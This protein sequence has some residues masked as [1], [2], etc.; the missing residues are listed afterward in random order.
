MRSW[1]CSTGSSAARRRRPRRPRGQSAPPPPRREP[2]PESAEDPTAAFQ[3]QVDA[4]QELSAKE[5]TRK[6]GTSNAALRA[7]VARRLGELGDRAALRPLANVY[8]MHG[9]PE[10]LE[11]LRR[12]GRQLTTPLREY[13]V[14]LSII[15]DRRGR[16]MDM[17]AASRRW[18]SWAI[19]TASRA[20]TRTCRPPT[21]TRGCAPSRR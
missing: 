4:L 10:A 6:L 13:A 16:L 12:Y 17:L 1:A 5:L 14:D 3:A 7:A 8:L 2:P 21:S 15:G 9:D 18:S 11:A 20:S 19:C